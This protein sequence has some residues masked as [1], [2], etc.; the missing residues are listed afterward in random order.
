MHDRYPNRNSWCLL[1]WLRVILFTWYNKCWSHALTNTSRNCFTS[2]LG[3]PCLMLIH[4]IN[5]HIEQIIPLYL[6][7][8]NKNENFKKSHLVRSCDR[9]AVIFHHMYR[10]TKWPRDL[11]R[12]EADVKEKLRQQNVFKWS[13]YNLDLGC[14]LKIHV[15]KA[16]YS[17][18]CL[19]LV[20]ELLEGEAQW[21]TLRSLWATHEPD[22]GNPV[23]SLFF[24]SVA[25][26]W[27]ILSL[28]TLQP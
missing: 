10:C 11:Q 4:N 3:I 6:K 1:A 20:V 24:H 12:D 5:H 15:L 26:R 27:T 18:S 23:P 9:G 17:V 2:D 16:C 8:G 22:C 13:S 25:K 28:Y 7:F 21:K 19:W 14:L